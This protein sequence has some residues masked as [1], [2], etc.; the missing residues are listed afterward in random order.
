MRSDF[1]STRTS[2]RGGAKS[3][4]PRPDEVYDLRGLNLVAPDQVMPKGESPK[5]E[6]CRMYAR[7]E[8][9]SR[10]AI[11]TRKGTR[12]LSTPVGEAL[13]VQ[14]VAAP[15][16]GDAQFTAL[17]WIAQSFVPT[18]TGPLTKLEPEIKLITAG[19]GHVIVQIYTDVSG[20]PGV[21]IGQ[22]V[23]LE[24]GVSGAFQFLPT[25]FIDAPSV[26]NGTTYWALY[27][28]QS[29]G[30]AVYALNKTAAAGALTTVNPGSVYSA[31]GYTIRY[32]S[33]VS[34][35]GSIKGFTR[36]YPSNLVNR[37]MFAMNNDMYSVTDAGVATSISSAINTL[38]TK[39]RFAHVNDI[40]Y[41][42]DGNNTPKK[43]D[44]TTVSDVANAPATPTHVIVHQ[45]RLFYIP[46]ADP[47][48][49]VF[50]NLFAFETY[51]S[52]DF[53]YVPNPK[54]PDKIAGWLT[55]Q[56]NLVIL[57]HETKHVIY[58]TDLG[59]FTRK[60]SIGTKGAVSQEAMCSDRNYIYFM[61]D[62]K[63]IYRWNGVE[64]ECI[65]EKV[66]P[67]LNGIQDTSKVRL[68]IYRNQLRVYYAADSD[69]NAEDMLL[70]E[71]SRKDS[72]KFLQWFHDIGRPVIGG[73]EWYLDNNQLIEMSSK[74]GA[75]YYAE[76]DES[77]MGKPIGMKYWTAYQAYGSGSAKDRIKKFRPYIRPTDSPLTMSIG[78]DIDFRNDPTMNN[79]DVDPGGS[80]WGEFVWGDGT[81]WG[82]NIALIQDKV[83]MSGRGNFTQYR[84]ECSQVEAPVELYGYLSLLKIG[85]VR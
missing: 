62:D 49:V 21:M 47:T 70:C 2:R 5:A 13:N 17:N 1:T 82:D 15:S 61:A 8:S 33:Y 37:T 76:M 28:V 75:F 16:G 12:R 56:D 41:W 73:L 3:S 24:G 32:K 74:C 31:A 42:V 66:E 57:T 65:S 64:D 30:S 20:A 29:G 81:L 6:N 85:R 50:S 11:R 38:A 10:V 44:G 59:S 54:S 72:N 63:Q 69:T 46:S 58:G 19:L 55:F 84:F 52:T 22:G 14:N 25:Y 77:D 26:T 34:T 79:Y 36:R 53:F 60:E 78:K 68:S 83:P 27:K 45:N 51:S 71:L 23:I 18:S 40:S 48:R 9:E 35:A 4:I 39:V 80:I 43:W 67:L 7:E